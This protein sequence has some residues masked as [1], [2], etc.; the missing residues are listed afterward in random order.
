MINEEK[1]L[2]WLDDARDPFDPEVDWLVFSPIGRNVK[3]IWVKDYDS[4]VEYIE[5]NKLPDGI[6]F[7]H[8]LGEGN[9]GY[10]CVNWLINYCMDNG[11]KF[12]PAGFQ[13]A[14]PVGRENMMAKIENFR[15]I[16]K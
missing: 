6:C 12:P 1:I 13:S 2:L 16:W 8:D 15:K 3:T 14:N 4:F 7:D 11:C 10:D 5:N 9:S